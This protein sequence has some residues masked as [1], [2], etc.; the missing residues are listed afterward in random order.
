MYYE[1]LMR[2]IT[3]L[4]VFKYLEF[5]FRGSGILAWNPDPYPKFH[6]IPNPVHWCRTTKT[7]LSSFLLIKTCMWYKQTITLQATREVM[8]F[9]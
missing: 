6:G 8:S 3:S 2:L 4:I 5:G 7:R 9:A 1:L